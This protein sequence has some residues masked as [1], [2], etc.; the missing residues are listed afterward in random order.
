[1]I[2]FAW[3]IVRWHKKPAWDGS[4]VWSSFLPTNP[5]C[6]HTPAQDLVDDFLTILHP[7]SGVSTNWN[8]DIVGPACHR[9]AERL[10][11]RPQSYQGTSACIS[12]TWRAGV[13]CWSSAQGFNCSVHLEDLCSDKPVNTILSLLC[14]SEDCVT[15]LYKI[16]Y[17]VYNFVLHTAFLVGNVVSSVWGWTTSYHFLWLSLSPRSQVYITSTVL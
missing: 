10:E 15:A 5:S 16:K 3:I 12:A 2:H 13:W 7:W 4:D 8:T 11:H 14:V 17:H 1:M 6:S 9:L